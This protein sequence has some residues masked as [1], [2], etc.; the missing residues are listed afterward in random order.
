MIALMLVFATLSA[1]GQDTTFDGHNWKAPYQLPEP[2]DW[3][4]ERFLIPISFAPRI[5]YK[6][7]EDIRFTP[8]WANKDS[9]EYWTYAFLWW[10]DGTP[11]IDEKVMSQN[12]G[13]YYNGLIQINREGFKV[14]KEIATHAT[15]S[16]KEITA[17]NGD[18]KTFT[19]TITMLDYMSHTTITLNCIAHLKT[20]PDQNKTVVFYQLS[21]KPIGHANW[22]KMDKLWQEFKCKI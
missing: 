22:A 5:P 7:V 21:P 13:D 6:G 17:V 8:G 14:P 4:I 1:Y 18:L 9:E 11:A 3:G 15:A 12:M 19:G 2:K 10:L 20:C 16:F